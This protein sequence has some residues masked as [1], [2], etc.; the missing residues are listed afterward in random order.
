M[1]RVPAHFKL[2]NGR[3]KYL[4]K[5]ALRGVLP[6]EILDRRKMGFGV[7][8]GGWL[9]G[10]LKD[11]LVDTVLSERAMARGYFKPQAVREMVQTHMAGSD[12]YQYILWDLLMLERWHEI[13]IDRSPAVEE[14]AAAAG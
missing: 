14:P 12:A 6:D 10:S 3:S 13:F 8:L 1:A 5:S 11:L 7:P 4:L 9:R 2:R